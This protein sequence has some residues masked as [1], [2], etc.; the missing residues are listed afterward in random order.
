MISASDLFNADLLSL[1]DPYCVLSLNG[2]QNVRTRVIED[3]C[4]PV[5]QETFEFL[6]FDVRADVLTIQVFDED[7]FGPGDFLG[8]CSVP[9]DRIAAAANK[10]KEEKGMFDERIT[11]HGHPGEKKP[12]QGTLH[13]SGSITIPSREREEDPSSICADASQ[14]N[15]A[16]YEGVA[17]LEGELT[18]IKLELHEKLAKEKEE[19]QKKEKEK[20]EKEKKE[21]EKK[22]KEEKEKKEKEEKEKEEKDKK[23]KEKEKEAKERETK[24]KIVAAAPAS[25][26]SAVASDA[27][28]AKPNAGVSASK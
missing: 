8:E 28:S 14:L 12:W 13:I 6:L 7:L 18:K 26:P 27:P 1:S 5:W 25:S 17:D 20:E 2:A 21:K 24:D 23:G 9:L 3:N 10:K 15:A 4:N 11:L 22:E 16:Q 19:R